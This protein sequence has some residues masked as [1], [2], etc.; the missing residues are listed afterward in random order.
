MVATESDTISHRPRRVH[1]ATA[2]V[3]AAARAE[4]RCQCYNPR[5][6]LGWEEG[7]RALLERHRGED[8]AAR[9]GARIET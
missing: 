3:E 9:G 4:R 8:D 6:E 2:A 7:G 5:G 1:P